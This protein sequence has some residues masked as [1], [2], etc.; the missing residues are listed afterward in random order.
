[1]AIENM[2]GGGTMITGN[3][4]K[5]FA[6]MQVASALAIE[7]NHPGMQLTRISGIQ[8]A[9]NHG[10]IPRDKRGN[11]KQALILTVQAIREQRPDYEPNPTVAKALAAV[12]T[13]K[14]KA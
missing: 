4:I 5:I 14:A 3:D 6:L 1:M 9:K 8:A 13:K 2:P 12:T 7:I 11:K 10:I